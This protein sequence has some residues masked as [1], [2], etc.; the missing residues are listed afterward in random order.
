MKAA[1]MI[2]DNRMKVIAEA[3]EHCGLEVIC[4]ADE[5]SMKAIEAAADMLDFLILPIRG[6][7]DAG[8]LHVPGTDYPA[9]PMIA[10]LRPEVPVITG[11][12]TDYLKA[13]DHP[14][15]CYYDDEDVRNA[16]AALTAE[17]VLYYFMDKT[18]RSMFEYTVD[19]VGYGHTG[20]QIVKLFACLGIAVRVVTDQEPEEGGI[21]MISYDIWK[22]GQPADVIIN[23]APARVITKEMAEGYRKKVLIIDIASN[24]VGVD[25]EVYGMNGIRVEAAPGLP[26]L[27]AEESAGNILAEYLIRKWNLDEQ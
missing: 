13:L 17:G 7:D 1:V 10:R 9:G 4:G 19:L 22:K 20:R 25:P 2:S 18:P 16:N 27:V 21:P 5:T 6:V 24:R 12:M 3:L 23:T 11:L 15:F 8:M 14:V 26:G